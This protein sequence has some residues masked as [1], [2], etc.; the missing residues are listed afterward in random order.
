MMQIGEQDIENMLV[1]SI[2]H[3]HGIKRKQFQKHQ[4]KNKK[5]FHSIQNIFQTKIYFGRMRLLKNLKPLNTS[6]LD[7]NS[8]VIIITSK[9]NW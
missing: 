8:N 4:N 3:E 1:T 5:P 2:V 6:T 9:H 7:T